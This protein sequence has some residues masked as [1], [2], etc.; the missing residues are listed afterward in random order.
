MPPLVPEHAFKYRKRHAEVAGEGE[1][2]AISFRTDREPAVARAQLHDV[3]EQIVHVVIIEIGLG[4]DDRVGGG[5]VHSPCGRTRTSE[6]C[7]GAA[8]AAARAA[9]VRNPVP[10]K[11]PT[12]AESITAGRQPPAGRWGKWWLVPERGVVQVPD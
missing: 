6:R 11:P 8:A 1:E 7:G 3:H 2:R 9:R 12:G 4:E 5:S 10:G